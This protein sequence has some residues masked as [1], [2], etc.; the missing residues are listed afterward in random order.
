MRTI[1]AP[2]ACRVWIADPYE[3]GILNP[4]IAAC[5]HFARVFDA[6]SFL[7]VADELHEWIEEGVVSARPTIVIGKLQ[8]D[9]PLDVELFRTMEDLRIEIRLFQALEVWRL[10][11][12]LDAGYDG[13]LARYGMLVDTLA[14]RQPILPLPLL[15]K[16]SD[17]YRSSRPRIMVLGLESTG[18]TAIMPRETRAW[19]HSRGHGFPADIARLDAISNYPNY[20]QARIATQSRKTVEWI[21]K[22]RT[23]G[24]DGA[25]ADDQLIEPLWNDLVKI[26]IATGSPIDEASVAEITRSLISI[27]LAVLQPDVVLFMVDQSEESA[28]ARSVAG[29][30]TY[31]IPG[32]P[33]RL[34]RQ[35][36]GGGL[37]NASYRVCREAEFESD[38]HRASALED[39]LRTELGLH[40]P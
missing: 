2:L 33:P 36:A 18:C 37:P 27:E 25:T 29:A 31:D 6:D 17:S 32:T 4:D 38:D 19:F 7:S 10:T 30:R 24:A 12:G 39:L 1:A 35:V 20:A 16:V 40:V 23:K 28:I 11:T 14:R 26:P 22:V 15:I 3:N 21:T 13:A 9:P 34:A 8:C 5:G